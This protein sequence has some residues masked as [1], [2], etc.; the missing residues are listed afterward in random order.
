MPLA[1]CVLLDF[2]DLDERAAKRRCAILRTIPTGA[3]LVVVVGSLAPMY[4]ATYLLAEHVSRL[5]IELWG[6]PYAVPQ[7]LEALRGGGIL[8][9]GT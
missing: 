7:W 8:A 4:E 2:R 6:E 5:Q 9:V 1:G 3:R